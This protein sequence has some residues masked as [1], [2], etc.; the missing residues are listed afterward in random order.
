M[1]ENISLKFI[2]TPSRY[3]IKSVLVIDDNN[4]HREETEK[5]LKKIMPENTRLFGLK[6]NRSFLKK[7][8]YDD[9]D[10]IIVHAKFSI[11]NLSFM[12]GMNII[13]TCYKSNKRI[14][15]LSKQDY[16]HKLY[17]KFGKHIDGIRGMEYLKIPY[18]YDDL[19]CSVRKLSKVRKPFNENLFN[20]SL[21]V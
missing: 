3:P 21:K 1:K 16:K 19:A 13:E 2:N 9:F 6:Y 14:L 17:K 18:T 8:I 4:K 15:I 12:S 10:L 20:E 5:H 7:F 11:K